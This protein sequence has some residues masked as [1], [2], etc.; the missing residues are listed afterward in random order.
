[1]E[2]LTIGTLTVK[3]GTKTLPFEPGKQPDRAPSDGAVEVYADGNYVVAKSTQDGTEDAL[4][5]SPYNA[6]RIWAMLGILLG[7]K[8]PSNLEIKL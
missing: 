3:I 7:V 5:M 1:M 8:M 2:E 6:F 4:V